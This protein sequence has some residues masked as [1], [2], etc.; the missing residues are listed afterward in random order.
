MEKWINRNNDNVFIYFKF[1][2]H[3]TKFTTKQTFHI[4]INYKPLAIMKLDRIKRRRNHSDCNNPFPISSLF[5]LPFLSHSLPLSHIF[6]TTDSG[7][8]YTYGN[9]VCLYIRKYT[10]IYTR[11]QQHIH[12]DI[13]IQK[14]TNF[15]THASKPR[16]T[17]IQ[18]TT[19]LFKQNINHIEIFRTD[20]VIELQRSQGW[21]TREH[22]SCHQSLGTWAWRSKISRS[23]LVQAEWPVEF[24]RDFNIIKRKLSRATLLF[25]WVIIEPSGTFELIHQIAI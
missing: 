19:Y 8:I 16:Y 9:D 2:H 13:K 18:I 11:E 10:Y 25:S 14:H 22:I 17:C 12:K 24:Q 23:S 20:A 15:G 4:H 5:T 1:H 6:P 3:T 7:N 21:R